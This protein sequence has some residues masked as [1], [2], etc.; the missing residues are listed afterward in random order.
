MGRGSAADGQFWFLSLHIDTRAFTYNLRSFSFTK[1]ILKQLAMSE[2]HRHKEK[3]LP[4]RQGTG[5][6][7][8]HV[9]ASCA[10]ICRVHVMALFWELVLSFPEGGVSGRLGNGQLPGAQE[11]PSWPPSWTH[12]HPGPA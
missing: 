10:I 7:G 9:A 4:M 12:T 2:R 3:M 6:Q 5:C 1:S 11:W 8:V